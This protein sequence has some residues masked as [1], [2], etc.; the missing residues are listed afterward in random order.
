M[1][2][3]SRVAKAFRFGKNRYFIGKDLDSNFYYEYPSL[4][5]SLDPRKTRRVIKYRVH[6]ELG[7]HDQ[8]ALP[9][10]WLMWLR[11]TRKSAP[12]IEV[13]EKVHA[14]GRTY[15]NT[16]LEAVL[17]GTDARYRAH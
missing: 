16:D 7:E 11:H 13:R 6:K 17:L 3:L 8:N 15:K 4:D 2:F 1:S 9:V 10:Q 14:T 5:G 12:S